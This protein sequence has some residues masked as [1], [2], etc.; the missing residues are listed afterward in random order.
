MRRN[1]PAVVSPP[2][3]RAITLWLPFFWILAWLRSLM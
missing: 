3:M 2:H 1:S